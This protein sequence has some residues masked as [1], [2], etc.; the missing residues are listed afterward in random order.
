ME[1]NLFL[2][3]GGTG[4]T[5]RIIENIK[6]DA[7]EGRQVF[8]IVPEQQSFSAERRLLSVLPPNA[9][10]TV[11]VLS[12]SR[13]ANRIFRQYG[14]LSY[15]YATPGIRAVLMWHELCELSFLFEEYNDRDIADPAL[16]ELMLSAVNEFRSYGI[17]PEKLENTLKR[18]PEGSPLKPKL[19]DISLLY[20]TYQNR[21]RE[22]Y[23]DAAEDLDRLDALLRTHRFFCGTSVYLDYFTSFT[24]PEYNILK[25]ILTTADKT[26]L[27]LGCETVSETAPH[28]VT[29]T[30][31]L[32]RVLRL[33]KNAD[34]PVNEQH[35]SVNHRAKSPELAFLQ[36][37]LWHLDHATA[38]Y[39]APTGESGNGEAPISFVRCEDPY[40]E[41]DAVCTRI[42]SLVKHKNL[43]FRDIVVITRDTKDYDG[44]LNAALEKYHIPCFYAEKTDL[45]SLPPIKLV[46]SA[47]R[48]VE[49]DFRTTDILSLIKT[50][51]CPI[52]NRE[53]DAFETYISTWR[54]RG[55]D[56]ITDEWKMHPDGYS[57][58]GR[59]S[60]RA[61]W[62][63]EAANRVRQTLIPPLLELRESLA[64]ELTVPEMCNALY[65]YMEK[66]H[67]KETIRLRSAQ[68]WELGESEHVR[69]MELLRLYQT[70]LDVLEDLAHALPEAK[71]TS[72][73][74][75][76][77]L[78]LVF[79]RTEVASIPDTADQVLVGSASMLRTDEP[80][81]A[82][83]IGLC[84]DVFPRA[85]TDDGVFTDADK[86]ELEA[87]GIVL[88]SDTASRSSDEL[89]FVSRAV[90]APSDSLC[91][92]YSATDCDG[93]S[94]RP[95]MAFE[96]ARKSLPHIPLISYGN[97]PPIDRLWN[98]EV[99]FEALPDLK[100]TPCGQALREIFADNAQFR[101]KLSALNTPVSQPECKVSPETA[102]IVFPPKLSLTQT[103]L[104]RYV[105]CHF[106][107]YC[108]FILGLKQEAKA[109]IRYNDI[110]TF[111][112]AVLEQFFRRATQN[113]H[114]DA[115]LTTGEIEVMVD[116]ILKDYLEDLCPVGGKPSNRLLHLFS[117]LRRLSLLMIENLREEFSHAAFTPAFFE[118]N[119]CENRDGY[120]APMELHLE[121]GDSVSLRGIIDRVDLFH[122]DG[123]LYLRIVDYKTGSKAFSMD[124]VQHGINVQLLLYLFTLLEN[125]PPAFLKKLGLQPGEKLLP[126]GVLYLSANVP[127]INIDKD[128]S[129]EEIHALAE[130]KL[131]RHGL[132]LDAPEVL[133]AMSD[134]LS[135][136][137]LGDVKKKTDKATGEAVLS[138]DGL[139]SM[140][141]FREIGEQLKE[142]IRS[143]AKTMKRGNANAVP[144]TGG[145]HDP[146]STCAMRSV[147]RCSAP[148]KRR[149]P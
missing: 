141:R 46:R 143:I 131:E 122:K 147:C 49:N 110:G 88:S 112:H 3:H 105:L 108:D 16:T 51:L 18:M 137:F 114:F 71:L 62:V 125:S 56:Y 116:S 26:T 132:L 68:I 136:A 142:T 90:H 133:S 39:T 52:E 106:R 45:S 139:V 23:D 38:T 107:Y 8:L 32:S 9:Q 93:K 55:K 123:C 115:A 69:A 85:V 109:E 50:G 20:A 33:A 24:E 63:L 119:I 149:R 104:D 75:A 31:T 87:L 40:E 6:K 36:E 57:A 2:G 42:L 54:L 134:Q 12:F 17:S 13:L 27:A 66:M 29:I 101:E 113:G 148:Q 80:K 48:I 25:H 70:V 4:K 7:E 126:A 59:M 89:Y 15:H 58:Q 118:L 47:L 92:M 127:P 14:G 140:D 128:L 19:K 84:E 97:L 144:Y 103:R 30:D 79:D 98:P 64:K 43:H 124:D 1:L 74:F 120:P 111:I 21:L 117:R 60:E 102:A 129:P 78:G 81:V 11:E 76:T 67:I 145:G 53:V 121:N 100:N 77:A 94:R 73:E 146:C 135:P 99:A 91:L 83:L 34:C 41:A 35:F 61:A 37:E 5:R 28:L 86:K 96:R 82:I 95:S 10:L 44:I 72:G 65:Q 22:R 130:A 138:G